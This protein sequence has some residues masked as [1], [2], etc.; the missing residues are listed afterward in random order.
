MIDP[1]MNAQKG[2]NSHV[3]VST[4]Q[5]PEKRAHA[6]LHGLLRSLGSVVR[7]PSGGSGRDADAHGD[8]GRRNRDVGRYGRRRNRA[9]H[10][11]GARFSAGRH[12]HHP[13]GGRSDQTVH[14]GP[15]QRGRRRVAKALLCA[16]LVVLGIAIGEA[17][18]RSKVQVHTVLAVLPP[19]CHDARCSLLKP[20]V[21]TRTVYIKAKR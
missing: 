7:R 15:F 6:R 1:D 14:L 18:D 13:E 10:F 9:R 3:Q 16:L 11:G 5:G 19:G 4:G 20:L 8:E 2:G 12:H 17:K 21:E